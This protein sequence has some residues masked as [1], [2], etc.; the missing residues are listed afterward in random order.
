MSLDFLELS[1]DEIK[2]EQIRQDILRRKFNSRLKLT[3]QEEER[4]R[5][6]IIEEDL[7]RNLS[8]LHKQKAKKEKHKIRRRLAE[9]VATQGRYLE[10]SK[11][12]PVKSEKGFY[13]DIAEAV[14]KNDDDLCQCDIPKEATDSGE[15]LELPKFRNLKQIY[16]IKHGKF[17]NLLECNVCG[18]WNV[19]SLT[20]DLEQLVTAQKKMEK[21]PN[22]FEKLFTKE[23]TDVLL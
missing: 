1:D 16:S 4:A 13:K 8:L 19:R 21:E 10:A 17:M 12:T 11:I 22:P 7:K 6:M 18:V 9:I 15:L 23:K 20:N 3:P 14:L 5:A 2:K